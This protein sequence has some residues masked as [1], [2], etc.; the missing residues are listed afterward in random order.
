MTGLYFFTSWR[1]EFF[2]LNHSHISW[3]KENHLFIQAKEK[4]AHKH[5]P[6]LQILVSVACGNLE[7]CYSPWIGWQSLTGYF[8]TPP[9]PLPARYYVKLPQHFSSTQ[10]YS[11]V[12]RSTTKA[13]HNDLGQHSDPNIS[14]QNILQWPLAQCSSQMATKCPYNFTVS[15]LRLLNLFKSTWT[16]H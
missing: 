3:C 11:W 12:E 1:I 13:H 2:G 6:C 7:C 4:K 15:F 16:C 8:T 9:P 10:L 5:W 14:I